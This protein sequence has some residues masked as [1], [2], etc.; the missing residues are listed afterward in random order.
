M[1]LF[2]RLK[3]VNKPILLSLMDKNSDLAVT[4][5]LARR[6]RRCGKQITLME[7]ASAPRVIELI[8]GADLVISAR[9]HALILS[10]CIGVP[11]LGLSDDP[12]VTAF[13]HMAYK[14]LEAHPSRANF[15]VHFRQKRQM[16]LTLAADDAKRALALSYRDASFAK[17][18]DKKQE[19]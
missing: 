12:K 3:K 8:R 5:R 11:F 7:D 17:G 18:I 16:L 15:S 4:R 2:E 6:L 9:L 14:G 1:P 13:C 10:F 19:K